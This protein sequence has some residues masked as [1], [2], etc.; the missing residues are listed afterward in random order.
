MI[1]TMRLAEEEGAGEL[2]LEHAAPD[3]PRRA[4][5][6][7][8][9]RSRADRRRCSRAR[10][11]ARR[12]S[13]DAID[14]TPRTGS[15]RL[16]SPTHVSARRPRS[17]TC[18]ARCSRRRFQPALLL[19]VGVGRGIAAR[20]RHHHVGA[21]ARECH[22][23]G[24]SDSAQSAGPR[25]DRNPSV[26]IS[27]AHTLLARASGAATLLSLCASGQTSR[28]IVGRVAGS[29]VRGGGA[30][31]SVTRSPES[32]LFELRTGR[33]G[34]DSAGLPPPRTCDPAHHARRVRDLG[35]T[36]EGIGRRLCGRDSGQ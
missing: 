19:V 15:A 34:P 17:R 25:D 3:G 28:V 9:G 4:R 29:Q 20:A 11:C 7:A 1:G 22:R 13:C 26:E 27:H 36:T 21:F 30:T 5:S 23:G 8:R 32:Q 10:R 33:R 31:G 16:T 35:L 18:S 14:E 6:P 2:D 24:P 12:S